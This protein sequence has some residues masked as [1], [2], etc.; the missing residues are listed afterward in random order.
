ML[1]I[2]EAKWFTIFFLFLYRFEIFHN[3]F[4]KYEMTVLNF[5]F[6]SN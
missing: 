1:I 6:W 4:K 5:A 2:V 3:N